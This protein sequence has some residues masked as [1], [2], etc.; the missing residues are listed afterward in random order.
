M[1]IIDFETP[2]L[3]RIK[4]Y[5]SLYE[6]I[7]PQFEFL[8]SQIHLGHD[9]TRPTLECA[10]GYYKNNSVQFSPTETRYLAAIAQMQFV[11]FEEYFTLFHSPN[12]K[13]ARNQTVIQIG[14]N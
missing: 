13:Q 5:T 11:S 4:R 9:K 7:K 10:I 8:S 1:T 12:L 3:E 2:Y 14:S 6:E